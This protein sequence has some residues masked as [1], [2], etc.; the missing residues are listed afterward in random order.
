MKKIN[1]L[2]RRKEQ[3]KRKMLEKS[4][5]FLT[6]S[7]AQITRYFVNWDERTRAAFWTTDPRNAMKFKTHSGAEHYK[8]GSLK[9]RADVKVIKMDGTGLI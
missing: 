5:W 8:F 1:L 2:R 7:V 4:V 6:K 3:A 9:N